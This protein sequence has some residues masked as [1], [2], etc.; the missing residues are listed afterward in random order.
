MTATGAVTVIVTGAVEAVC[1]SVCVSVCAE[2][3]KWVTR[4]QQGIRASSAGA[5]HRLHVEEAPTF[6][7]FDF[8]FSVPYTPVLRIEIDGE[9]EIR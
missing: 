6:S 3:A 1:V 4:V 9:N 2:R 5:L 8:S 7:Q